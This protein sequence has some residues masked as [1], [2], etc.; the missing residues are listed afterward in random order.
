MPGHRAR[1]PLTGPLAPLIGMIGWHRG[2]RAPFVH[3]RRNP[4]DRPR[5]GRLDLSGGP[6]RCAGSLG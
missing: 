2:N 4:S 3:D 6:M 5:E 1:S